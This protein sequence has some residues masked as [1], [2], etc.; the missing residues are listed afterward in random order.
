MKTI[1]LFLLEGY[2]DWEAGYISAKL[3]KPDLGFQIQT[4]SLEDFNVRSQGNFSVNID[5][6]VDTFNDIKNLAALIFIGGTGWGNK[7]LI[8]GYDP[9]NYDYTSSQKITNLISACLNKAEI[10][11]AGICDGAT[12]LADNGFLDKITHTG[13]SLSHLKEKAPEYRGENFFKETQ[14]VY[15][16]KIITA[17]AS[18]PLEF[19]HQL[20]KQLQMLEDKEADQWYQTYKT[21]F[22]EYSIENFGAKKS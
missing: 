9:L 12:F 7:R 22:Y 18:A 13:N 17:N 20:L 8:R 14:A 10:L 21:G 16:Q 5:Y 3:N 19:T 6:K 1:L 2:A 11:I 15:D 4:M